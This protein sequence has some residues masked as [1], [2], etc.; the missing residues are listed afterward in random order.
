MNFLPVMSDTFLHGCRN[1]NLTGSGEVMKK[2]QI[3][4]QTEGQMYRKLGLWSGLLDREIFA[5]SKL[6]IFIELNR[7]VE[8]LHRTE[9]GGKVNREAGFIFY[10]WIKETGLVNLSRS[11][12]CRGAV[13]SLWTSQ[14][15]V[16]AM[17]DIYVTQYQCLCSAPPNQ[18]FNS[19][20]WA[21]L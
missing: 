11:S 5:H 10:H 7:V 19:S 6:C 8:L 3:D 21:S 17:V 13:F 18:V 1:V 4:G 2:W 15:F 14:G 20:F 9:Q 12:L 16:Q